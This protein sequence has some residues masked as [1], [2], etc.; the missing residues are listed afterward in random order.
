MT[1][2]QVIALEKVK[3][4]KVAQGKIETHHPCYLDAQDT[5]SVE[6]IK[7]VGHIYQQ[8]FIDIYIF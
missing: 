1:K 4:E 3:E 8:T 6:N 7:G 5:Y 2:S